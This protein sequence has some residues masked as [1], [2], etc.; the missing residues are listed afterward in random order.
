MFET[1]ADGWWRSDDMAHWTHVTPDKWPFEEMVA[2]AAL[3]DEL[4]FVGRNP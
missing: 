2:P 3:N 4:G 1:I